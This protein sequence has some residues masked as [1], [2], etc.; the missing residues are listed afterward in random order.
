MTRFCYVDIVDGILSVGMPMSSTSLSTH[1]TQVELSD[2][3]DRVC[4]NTCEHPWTNALKQLP[5]AKSTSGRHIPSSHLYFCN[6]ENNTL[7]THTHTF[8]FSQAPVPETF[9]TES[10]LYWNANA[11]MIEAWSGS[12]KHAQYSDHEIHLQRWLYKDDTLWL[13]PFS[14]QPAWARLDGCVAVLLHTA[15]SFYMEDVFDNDPL[16]WH[17]REGEIGREKGEWTIL[18][19]WGF[20]KTNLR[21]NTRIIF[22]LSIFV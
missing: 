20:P 1:S 22:Y 15:L 11:L 17:E 6:A 2:R 21:S 14:M 8:G 18:S 19:S 9:W 3:Q 16:W 4:I 12:F 5:L 10:G 7:I 13:F